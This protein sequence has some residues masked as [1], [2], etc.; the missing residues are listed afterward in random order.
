MRLQ[1]EQEEREE[2]ERIAEAE[3]QKRLRE[4]QERIKKLEDLDNFLGGVTAPLQENNNPMDDILSVKPVSI[5][6]KR[7]KMQGTIRQQQQAAEIQPSLSP[8]SPFN[9]LPSPVNNGLPGLNNLG[10]PSNLIPAKS[11]APLPVNIN[12]IKFEATNNAALNQIM[13]R[14]ISAISGIKNNTP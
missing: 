3:R 14:Q 8:N 6:S 10:L 12:P 1:Q 5:K 4:E 11:N 7:A 9:G 2:Q 13:E